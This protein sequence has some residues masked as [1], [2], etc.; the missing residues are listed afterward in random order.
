[1][2]NISNF[3]VPQK[4]GALARF[5]MSAR[6]WMASF[7]APAKQI[8]Q[9]LTFQYGS[10]SATIAALLG[11][12]KRFA[13]V[14]QTIYN[15]WALMEGDPIISS[16]LQ[17]L[18]TS[19]L[20]GHETSGKLVFIEKTT[21]AKD[22][23]RLGTIVDEI[24]T[25]LG[26]LFDKVAFP[27]CYTGAVFGDSYARIYCK[28][29]RGVVDLHV[30]DLLRPQL[31]QPFERGSRTVGYAVYIGD[32]NFERLDVTQVAR[33]K[34]PRT[35][36]VPQFG[37]VEK[38]IRQAL[39]ENDIDHLPVLPSMA[40]GS[41][42]Y[43]AE[44]PYDNLAASLLG[45]VGQ[46]WIDSI[47]ESIMTVNMESMTREQQ[48]RFAEDLKRMLQSSKDYAEKA[49]TSGM[50]ILQRIRHILPVFGEKQVATL[51]PMNGGQSGRAANITIDDVMVHARLLAGALGVDLSMLGFADQLSGGLGEGGFFRVSAQ[52]AERARV[53]RVALAEFFNQVVDIHTMHRYGIVFEPKDRPWQINFFGSI[54]ALEAEKQTTRTNMMN[55]G[56]QLAQAMQMMKEMGASEEIMI[57]YLTNQMQLDE[58]QAKLYATIVRQKEKAPS[59]DDDLGGGGFG[60]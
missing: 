6:R 60:M 55:A 43:N 28:K 45:M 34:M 26:T 12:G 1:M 37:I 15:K 33:F 18:V 59:D 5:G 25:T 50:P 36:F 16:A 19:A 14:R 21:P 48:E 56:M 13:R 38:A 41:L 39:T 24:A 7:I 42:L 29:N 3:P 30:D 54:S 20:G 32:R 49:V 58:D 10:G 44:E 22:D 51:A 11:T 47:D 17:L 27:I 23:K 52:A 35:Q 40:G 46:R 9:A 57:D 8:T 53:I 4:A 31:V 2:A